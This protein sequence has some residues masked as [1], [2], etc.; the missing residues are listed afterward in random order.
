MEELED[1]AIYGS[2]AG[3]GSKSDT[4]KPDNI[5]NIREQQLKKIREN[6]AAAQS[7]DP[8]IIY[9]NNIAARNKNDDSTS[10]NS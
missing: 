1:S 3:G 4:K 2:P 10:D 6:M 7:E 9:Q 5:I 8:E